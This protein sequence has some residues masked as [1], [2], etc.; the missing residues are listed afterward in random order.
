MSAIPTKAWFIGILCV[1]FL[2]T[3]KSLSL[4]PAKWQRPLDKAESLESTLYS[5]LLPGVVLGYVTG[6]GG[7]F[8]SDCPA[9]V[10]YP[11]RVVPVIVLH[12]WKSKHCLTKGW[13]RALSWCPVLSTFR[14]CI[15]SLRVDRLLVELV[16]V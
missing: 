4:V 8:L 2:F 1:L 3:A 14:Q 11:G 16:L 12:C 9:V 10:S 13:L 15:A 6:K 5:C 7:R